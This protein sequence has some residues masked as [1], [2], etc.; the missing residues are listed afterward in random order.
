[1]TRQQKIIF[2]SL[3]V[4]LALTG[5]YVSKKQTQE[6]RRQ[7][8]IVESKA[9]IES[10]KI[11]L[12]NQSQQRAVIQ[13]HILNDTKSLTPQLKALIDES[14]LITFKT[15]QDF[16][17]Y[18]MK[19]GQVQEVITEKIINGLKTKNKKWNS[20]FKSKIRELELAEKNLNETRMQFS[21]VALKLAKDE[22]QIPIT[23][24]SDINLL[25]SVQK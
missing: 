17:D 3:V 5:L 8:D 10:L 1:M 11:S 14:N 9:R 25:Q 6:T 4:I 2:P 7:A 16:N 18:E 15:Q 23:F 24:L 22:K 21:S 19:Q 13:T 20:Y 12:I